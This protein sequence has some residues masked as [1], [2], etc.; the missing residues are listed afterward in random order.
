[1]KLW[2]LLREALRLVGRRRSLILAP[3]LVLLVLLTL[4]AFYVG[5]GTLVTFIYAGF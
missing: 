2:Y 1:M 3:L 4:I 5:P